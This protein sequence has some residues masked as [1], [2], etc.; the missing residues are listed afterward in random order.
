MPT[1]D[2]DNLRQ[3]GP[4]VGV[5]GMVA[6]ETWTDWTPGPYNAF[7]TT[8]KRTYEYNMMAH[9]DAT[10]KAA[11]HIVRFMILSKLGGY[12]N[13]DEAV[14][15]RVDGLLDKIDGGMRIVA[16][17]MLSSLWAGYAVLEKEWETTAS[18]WYIR[19][20]PL[21]HPLTFF[22]QK[23]DDCGI[24]LNPVVKKV[25]E[26]IQ[27]EHSDDLQWSDVEAKLPIEKVVYWPLL[28]EAREEVCGNSLLSG[29]RRAW[30][31]RVKQ[32]TYWN[33]F[34]EK[35]ACPTPVFWVP[36]TS[37]TDTN[38]E[39]KQLTDVLTSHYERLQP[40][41]MLAIPI[42]P[43][44]NNKLDTISP[45]GDGD[46]FERVCKYWDGQLYKSI[47][48]PR[49]L[50]E[51]PEHGSRAQASTNLDLF[52]L[53]LDGIRTEMGEVIIQQIVRPLIV[54]NV[55]DVEDFGE[56]EFDELTDKD[57]QMLAQIFEMIERG[58]AQAV[59]SGGVLS[60]A[61]DDKLRNTFSDVYAT[62]EEVDAAQAEED[63]E[64]EKLRAQEMP[65]QPGDVPEEV[66]V[67]LRIPENA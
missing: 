8:K 9:Y 49:M 66:P 60:P 31:S 26:V 53:V 30:F 20:M 61:D 5:S 41:Q 25:T 45:V 11:L 36:Q 47:L 4:P 54:Y 18:E 34:V 6:T 52:L 65:Q 33:T 19:D 59:Q 23:K 32:E 62:S 50:M 2:T 24:K 63:A 29:A 39:Q 43:D 27:Y 28:Q 12:H 13:E 46:A 3:Q 51:E 44:T 38:G 67:Q 1:T 58:K 22:A 16:Q 15:E 7:P 56:W 14:Q 40:G 21:L 57:L 48:T 17:R 55:G 10:I 42:D 37:V 35:C 64:R